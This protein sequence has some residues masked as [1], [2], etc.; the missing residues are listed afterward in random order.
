MIFGFNA[1]QPNPTHEE[2]KVNRKIKTIQV[3]VRLPVQM[4]RAIKVRAASE[5]VTRSQIVR[6]SLREFLGEGATKNA[7]KAK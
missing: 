2:S 1:A 6:R 3:A 5:G 4:A 7:G